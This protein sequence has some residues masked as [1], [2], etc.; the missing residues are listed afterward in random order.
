MLLIILLFYL[1]SKSSVEDVRGSIF[2]IR[3]EMFLY[4]YE[5]DLL[6]TTA[7]RELRRL[8]NG[9]IRFAHRASLTRVAVYSWASDVTEQERRG[10]SLHS[11]IVRSIEKLRPEHRDAFAAAHERF[12][13]CLM[14]HVVRSFPPFTPL[15]LIACL[16]FVG[17]SAVGRIDRTWRPRIVNRA[18][19]I[20]PIAA[21]EE[22]AGQAA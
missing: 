14:I 16:G 3:D 17:I 5:N 12:A 2:E 8:M 13:V 21:L 4:A 11:R 1:F 22:E 9:A 10:R 18:L 7:H 20:F 6:D 15:Y 19:M